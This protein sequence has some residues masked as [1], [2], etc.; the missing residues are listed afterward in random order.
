M[1]F[2]HCKKNCSV[3]P[4]LPGRLALQLV[5]VRF[6]VLELEC[7]PTG[8]RGGLFLSLRSLGGSAS[9]NLHSR[10]MGG[11]G[12]HNTLVIVILTP[13]GYTSSNEGPL[14]LDLRSQV[15]VIEWVDDTS[16]SAGWDG[17]SMEVGPG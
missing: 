10:G 5:Q 16:W 17:E 4:L 11:Q 7:A 6:V 2:W 3:L 8:F 12:M 9:K 14:R 15:K 13:A 1:K